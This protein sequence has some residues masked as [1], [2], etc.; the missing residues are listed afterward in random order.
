MGV[1][2]EP[3]IVYTI[4]VAVL[5]I[6]KYKANNV[7]LIRGMSILFHDSPDCVNSSLLI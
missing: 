3:A 4:A 2:L 6:A 7:A 1:Y 5:Q